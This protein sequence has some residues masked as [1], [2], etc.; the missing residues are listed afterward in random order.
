[1]IFFSLSGNISWM[2]VTGKRIF[3]DLGSESRHRETELELKKVENDIS[4][5]SGS[6]YYTLPYNVR[7]YT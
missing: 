3:E 7:R 1:M 4:R 2:A 6:I 5:V